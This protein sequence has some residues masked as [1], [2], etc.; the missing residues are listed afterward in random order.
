M[1]PPGENSE[2]YI[3]LMSGTSLDGIDG[4]LITCS[5]QGRCH[6]AHTAYQPFDAELRTQ[7]LALSQTADNDL[8]SAALAGIRLARRYA[9]TVARLLADT[10]L[11]PA[12]IRG[13]GCHGQTVRHRPEQGFSIQLGNPALLAELAGIT[14]VADFR[15]RDLAAGGQGAPLVPAFHQ[16]Y[17]SQPPANRVIVNIGGISNLTYLT[18]T[19]D[20]ALG[21]D[22]GP[23]NLLLDAWAE[24]HLHKPY[25]HDGAWAAR[26]TV[27]PELLAALHALP[28]FHRPPP[29][30]TG[31]ETFNLAWL[32][33]WLTTDYAAADVQATL[34]QLTATAIADAIHDYCP[35]TQE[36]YLCGGGAH[37]STLRRALASLLP[38]VP[39]KLTDERGIAADWV[40]AFAFAWLA[41][42]TLHHAPG[43]LPAVTGA[44]HPC[45][46]GAIYLA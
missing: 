27:I 1:P 22:C 2:Y 11:T 13:I 32:D 9:E 24:R 30:S 14:I 33:K 23:G 12:Q 4:A 42:Q 16:A 29:K 3:G 28:F 44:K 34:L 19:G 7:L 10:G 40:E 6:L 39:L 41:R 18:A 37:N 46:L 36:V 25:D 17:F 20:T 45:I 38:G 15:S 8:E 35:Q 5:A 26:G 31:R 21:F 43:N